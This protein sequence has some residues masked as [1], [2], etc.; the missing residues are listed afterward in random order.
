MYDYA[1]TCYIIL[2]YIY[3]YPKYIILYIIY[4]YTF[5]YIYIYTYI[6]IYIYILC[7]YTT[8]PKHL[9]IILDTRLSFEK[10]LET[11]LLK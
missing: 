5:I 8:S 6:L 9:D 7:I 11:V 4:I 1:H 2:Y 3:I 10:H